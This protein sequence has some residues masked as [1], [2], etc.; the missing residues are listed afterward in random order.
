MNTPVTKDTIIISQQRQIRELQAALKQAE[1][2]NA[3]LRVILAIAIEESRPVVISKERAQTITPNFIIDY[4][5]D[6]GMIIKN[7]R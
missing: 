3:E 1:R 5:I 6:G 4:N 2:D 7:R